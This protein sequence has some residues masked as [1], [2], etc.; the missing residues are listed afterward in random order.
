MR[1]DETRGPVRHIWNDNDLGLFEDSC[2]EVYYFYN[3]FIT[4]EIDRRK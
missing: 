3:V 2:V 1:P 4:N